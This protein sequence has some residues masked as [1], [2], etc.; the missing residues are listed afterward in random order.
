MNIARRKNKIVKQNR[1]RCSPICCAVNLMCKINAE[2][3][4]RKCVTS[5]KACLPLT[6]NGRSFGS[7]R[8][9]GKLFISLHVLRTFCSVFRYGL[10][11]I[12]HRK[13]SAMAYGAATIIGIC[14]LCDW[15]AV[16]KH[17]PYYGSKYK[18]GSPKMY[19]H[20]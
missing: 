8:Q 16:C 14:W 5:A 12:I 18:Q 11:F 13:E 19:S 7:K 1:L 15:Q 3:A 20:Y 17:I 6:G 4:K 9:F 10:K 2:H